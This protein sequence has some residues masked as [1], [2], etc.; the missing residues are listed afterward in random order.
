MHLTPNEIR[1]KYLSFFEAR[2]HTRMPSDSLVPANDPSLLFTGAG[3]NQFKD[4]FL[5]RG[6]RGLRRATTSQ[7]CLRTG[8]LDN[9]GRTCGHHSFF[10]MLG[11]FSFGDYFKREAIAWAWEFLTREMAIPGEKLS[12]TVYVDDT[13]AFEVWR[14]EVRIPVSRIFRLGAKSNFW[15][16][17]APADGPN[18]PCGPCS[19]IFFD[20][21]VQPGCP[22]LAKC[23]P[24][25]D[26]GRYIEVWNLVFTQFDRQDG[27]KLVPLPQKNIDTGMGFERLVAVAEGVHRTLET[28]LFRGLREA[29]AVAAG[30]TA[31]T[32]AG[33][34][35]VRVRR[36]AD[37]VRSAS[38]L[39]G[40][41][42]RPGNEGRG[43]VLR[44]LIRRAIR[45]GAGLGIRKPFLADMV[46]EV[47]AAMGDAYPDLRRGADLLASV[48]AAEEAQFGRTFE[49]GMRRLEAAVESIRASGGAALPGDVGF[50]LHDTYGFPVE[51][52]AE[53]VTEQGLGFDRARFDV[54][55]E[56]QRDRAR[57]ARKMTDNIFERGAVGSLEDAGVAPTS[58]LGYEEMPGAERRGTY[59]R[60]TLRGIVDESAN[61][62]VAELAPGGEG[63]LVLDRT[64][65]YAESGGQ[66]GD[67][68][69]IRFE[70]G[71]FEVRDTVGLTGYS[72]HRGTWKGAVPLVPGTACE[73]MVDGARRDA[74]RRNHTGT[75][76]LHRALKQVLGERV[77]QAGSLVAADR[78]RFDFT[79][80]RGVSAEEMQIVEER[81]NAE[82]LRNEPV[83]KGPMPLEEAKRS[84]AM[85]LFG[86]KYPDPVRVVAAGDYSKELCGGTHCLRTGDI[87][88]LRILSEGGIASGIRR[89]EAVTGSAAVRKMQEDRETLTALGRSLG[90]PA[91][92]IGARIE[93]LQKEM[94]D[95]K[96]RPAVAAAGSGFDP[97]SG[98]P[99][100]G[101]RYVAFVHRVELAR[102]LIAAPLEAFAKRPGDAAVVLVVT[103]E[104]GK[105]TAL[106][107][108]NDAA[109]ASGFDAAQFL[110]AA[111][112]KGGGKRGAA[113]GTFPAGAPSIEQLRASVAAAIAPE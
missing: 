49:Q 56:E 105:V 96:K 103:T 1:E 58:F 113:Q 5:G 30:R 37:H 6:K 12:V 99:I 64:P 94:K 108:G 68:G 66:V 31:Y 10:E 104:G 74:I 54:L 46:P 52:T 7:K 63:A 9:V 36:I 18:G 33:E 62:T 77:N 20:Y 16:A 8:D 88:T 90:V 110:R 75:H 82:I 34:D 76:L 2:A 67:C 85:A 42:V 80:D 83:V 71:V 100:G 41:G 98:D 47:A 26:C 35:G 21:G 73:A 109:V 13:E 78:L 95:L 97:T 89:I 60:S 84:G 91:R 69:E 39:V 112:G 19:E 4:E 15:P 65:F 93:K 48:L 17:N 59:T 106:V 40:D 79:F 81:V 61:R 53:I 25:C 14:D 27:G 92:E 55:M 38:F 45:D 44:R 50:L 43:Y 23:D 72:M 70:A 102:D 3:M 107:T 87:G 28:S 29:V 32:S 57:G 51:M 111:G 24:A 86:E 22:D 11:N 101:S